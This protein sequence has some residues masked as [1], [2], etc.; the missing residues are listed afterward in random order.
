MSGITRD[1]I[2][3][4]AKKNNIAYREDNITF[5]N[6]KAVTELWVT[7]S[8]REI[9][10]IVELDGTVIGEGSPGPVWHTMYNILQAYKQTLL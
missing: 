3:E 2:L 9:V 10:P 4:L 1:V 6:I 7:S 5:A 8:I